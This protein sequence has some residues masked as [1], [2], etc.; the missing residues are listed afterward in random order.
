MS[1]TVAAPA[2]EPAAF[3]FSDENQELAKRIIA[4]YPA[5]RQASAV[6]P[7]LDLAQ[8]QN[9][10][11]LTQPIMD[12]IAAMLAMPPI[13]VY[14]VATFYTMYNHHPIGKHHIQVCT[15]TP[16][17][18]RG[19]DDVVAVCKR[20]LGIDLGETTPDGQFT[21]GEVECSG[22][23]VNAPVVQIGD[24]YYEDVGPEQ[25]ERIIDAFKRG[26]TPPA[27]SQTGRQTSCPEGGPTTLKAFCT[28]QGAD[29]QADD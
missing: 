1:A 17:W 11:W 28:P 14:E 19:S 6:M 8:R 2:G 20:K 24:D 27:G 18:L 5:G 15:T 7:L 21:L 4:K 13:R 10:G 12:H 26:E 23:C 3:A 29:A 9:G 25:M 16:C 22:A